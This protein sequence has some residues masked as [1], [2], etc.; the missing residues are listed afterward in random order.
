MQK[1]DAE[2]ARQVI[3][4]IFS[5]AGCR[6]EEARTISESLIESNL[7][8]HDSHGVVRTLR[9]I[10]F[11][12]NG[13]VQINQKAELIFDGGSLVSFDGNMGFGQSIGKQVMQVLADRAR[14][15][16]IAMSTVRRTGH[17]GRVG[18]WA[19]GLARME[20][21]SLHFLNTTGLAN[22]VTPYG[23]KERRLS[24]SVFC[25]GIPGGAEDPVILDMTTAATAEGKLLVA[26]NHNQNVPE[27]M[28]LTSEGEPTTDPNDFYSGGAILPFGGHKGSGLNLIADMMSGALSGGGCTAPGVDVLENTM[29]SIAIDLSRLPDPASVSQEVATFRK[30]VTSCTPIDPS[31]PVIFPGEKESITLTDR[32]MTGIPID[33]QTLSEICEAGNEVG[34]AKEKISDMLKQAKK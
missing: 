22:L 26:K 15:H 32:Q 27:G 4:S 31:N 1:Y 5:A 2:A 25:V 24:P 7:R 10:T 28:I 34:I 6:E 30:W 19:E 12:K 33:D 14:K 21:V 20:M 23:G 8:G 18:A 13:E 17:L 11:L 16:G 9:Y 29:T 3:E